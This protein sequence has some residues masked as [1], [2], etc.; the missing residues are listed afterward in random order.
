MFDTKGMTAS[1]M[2]LLVSGL[3]AVTTFG[4][5]VSGHVKMTASDTTSVSSFN[6]AGK[7]SDGKAPSAGKKY[8][9]AGWTMYTPNTGTATSPTI[10][11]FAGDELVAN[12]TIWPLGNDKNANRLTINN[13]ILLGS[14]AIQTSGHRPFFWGKT[15]LKESS[16]TKPVTFDGGTG[17][18][19]TGFA[20]ESYVFEH[21]ATM[22]GDGAQCLRFRATT[23]GGKDYYGNFA[24]TGS[25]TSFYGTYLLMARTSL[26]LNGRTDGTVEVG[27]GAML[28]TWFNRYPTTITGGGLQY[29]DTTVKNVNVAS[30]GTLEVSA[31]NTLTVANLHLAEGA[32][33]SLLAAGGRCGQIVVTGKLTVDGPVSLD[34]GS[35]WGVVTGAPPVYAT[36]TLAKGATGDAGLDLIEMD[37]SGISRIGT[38]P[39]ISRQIVTDEAGNRTIRYTQREIVQLVVSGTSEDGNNSPLICA[40]DTKNRYY[41][42]DGQAPTPGKDYYAGSGM[43]IN[44]PECEEPVE[45]AGDSLTLANGAYIPSGNKTYCTGFNVAEFGLTGES[46][47]QNWAGNVQPDSYEL[48]MMTIG[49]DMFSVTGTKGGI[50]RP[51]GNRMLRISSN[52]SGDGPLK[53]TSLEYASNEG[54]RGTI[55]L[56]GDNAAWSGKLTVTLKNDTRTRTSTWGNKV[57]NEGIFVRLIAG[58]D[59]SLGGPMTAFTPDGILVE[60]MSQL[61][62]T[63]DTVMD[64]ENRGVTFSGLARVLV[65]PDRMFAIMNPVRLQ[66]VLRLEGEGTFGLGGEM[67]FQGGSSI[68]AVGTNVVNVLSGALKVMHP[69]AFDGAEIHLMAD[70][71]KF[72]FDIEPD[73]EGMQQYG[74]M[75]VKTETPFVFGAGV[76]T[77][78]VEVDFGG[79]PD[80][81]PTVDYDLGLFTVKNK[82][83]AQDL[84]DRIRI[85]KSY[86]RNYLKLRMAE[87]DL[88]YWT[89]YAHFGPKPSAMIIYH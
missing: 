65:D 18:D 40:H 55:E 20:K 34:A 35:S 23:S 3:A 53:A 50:L 47:V 48:A 66:G 82:T 21:G 52:L 38:L 88:G 63:A 81:A 4:Y 77:I 11:T 76:S 79:G 42:S 24:L 71:T 28:R 44:M 85:R 67:S 15:T 58:G 12:G 75:D 60:Q 87:N 56:T 54:P 64:A 31:S 83:L 80:G 59:T 72:I 43:V 51:Y 45:F 73:E 29:F 9:V 5:D 2:V 7:W 41:W 33:L 78:E 10:L 46:Y 49:G 36:V 68:P 62:I 69:H 13:L 74:L 84:F 6:T 22:S 39:H 26:C 1:V 89:V 17:G 16:S 14:S 30:G 86:T 70:A 32:K 19:L 8:N 25:Q 57:P 37:E 27:E 61:R